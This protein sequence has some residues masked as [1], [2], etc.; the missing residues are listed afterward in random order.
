MLEFNNT[1]IITGHIKQLLS[2]FNLPKVRVYTRKNQQWAEE[3]PG[4]VEKYIVPTVKKFKAGTTAYDNVMQYNPYIKNGTLQF[5][6]YD[7]VKKTYAWEDSTDAFFYGLAITNWTKNLKIT[8][9]IY[10]YYTHE[11]LGEYLRFK[12]DYEEID[13][14]PLYNC[15]NNR[16]CAKLSYSWTST[17]GVK[18]EFNTN[19]P[20]Y[21]IFMI[22]VKLFKEYTIAIDCGTPVEMCCGLYGKYQDTKMDTFL[23]KAT[24]KK[25]NSM[26]FGQ[27]IVYDMLINDN[28]INAS[29]LAELAQCEEELKL[30]IK[31]P[32]NNDSSIVILEGD[33]RRWNDSFLKFNQNKLFRTQNYAVTNF[34]TND[35]RES[36]S[37][38]K[39]QDFKDFT[40]ITSLQ[41]LRSNTR[42]SYP[43]ADRLV[44]YLLGNAIDS[45]E[46]NIDNIRRVQ[47]TIKQNNTYKD[48][49]YVEGKE[50]I[51]GLFEIDG[52]P[53]DDLI[54]STD[55]KQVHVAYDTSRQIGGSVPQGTVK[56]DADDHYYY[57]NT[58]G[59]TYH[60]DEI[61]G[62]GQDYFELFVTGTITSA[63]KEWTGTYQPYKGTDPE[64]SQRTGRLIDEI[65]PEV[66]GVWT[67]SIRAIVYDKFN[68]TIKANN[69]DTNHDILGYVDKDIE[70]WYRANN[71]ND[72]KRPDY[73]TISSMDLYTGKDGLYSDYEEGNK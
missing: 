61:D 73:T 64:L 34:N 11:Y 20:N 69:N 59:T 27:P 51:G 48:I 17:S 66:D 38:L 9:N 32:I 28:V 58:D 37:G 6:V 8:N 5:Y 46:E 45:S 39:K 41:L 44:E 71:T 50:I 40:P 4:Q 63:A 56:Y 26:I 14:M 36:A 68:T 13:L 47:A 60:I 67:D 53:Y 57:Y 25:Y 23:P 54:I 16:Y 42:V 52:N 15:F 29:T 2:D 65:T 49:V 18:H 3:H 30:F 35:V 62:Q 7:T 24:Y 22:P 70:K 1:H 72:T 43:F 55:A 33:Y 31:L 12:R 19:N 21:K 10:D